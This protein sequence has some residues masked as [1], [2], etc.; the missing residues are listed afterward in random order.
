MN[1]DIK[2]LAKEIKEDTKSILFI[3]GAGVSA[4]SGLPTYRGQSGLYTNADPEEG[5]PIEVILSAST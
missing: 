5:I 1:D 4:D 2:S 3:T